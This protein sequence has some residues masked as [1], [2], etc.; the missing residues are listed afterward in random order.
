M[1]SMLPRVAAARQLGYLAQPRWGRIRRHRVRAGDRLRPFRSQFHGD[2]SREFPRYLSCVASPIRISGL[3]ST[4]AIG[5]LIR[6]LEI[7]DE[8]HNVGRTYS[9]PEQS[10]G[11]FLHLGLATVQHVPERLDGRCGGPGGNCGAGDRTSSS[12]N[13]PLRVCR[14]GNRTWR[15]RGPPLVVCHV[16]VLECHHGPAILARII[17]ALRV[18]GGLAGFN[19]SLSTGPATRHVSRREKTGG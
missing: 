4:A 1:F 8:D 2:A 3:P 19:E 18:G 5:W 12:D 14:D 10:V 6:K 16:S 11:C 15:D 7:H 13:R 17:H 9:L